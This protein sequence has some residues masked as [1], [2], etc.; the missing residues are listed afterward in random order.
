MYASSAERQG[1]YAPARRQ[2]TVFAVITLLL[3]IVTIVIAIWCT[4]NFNK[5]LKPHIQGNRSDSPDGRKQYYMD[6]VSTNQPIGGSRM[7]ID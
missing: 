5:G 2:L 3:L 7:E 4:H 6:N 1:Q